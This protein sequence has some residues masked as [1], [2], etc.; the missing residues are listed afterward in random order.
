MYHDTLENLEG[1]KDSLVGIKNS[2]EPTAK[3]TKM[4]ATDNENGSD[5]YH[6]SLTSI[7][8]LT[9][10]TATDSGIDEDDEYHDS[11]TIGSV[12][13]ETDNIITAHQYGPF[14]Q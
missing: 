10:I 9:D 5:V 13:E 12:P 14:L 11:L 7:I 2:I 4:E 3:T 8:S 6:D 1:L